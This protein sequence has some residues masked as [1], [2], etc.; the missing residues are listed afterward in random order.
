MDNQQK[1]I[2]TI[3]QE[4]A[5]S[6]KDLPQHLQEK[7]FELAVQQLS[8][9]I[10]TTQSGAATLIIDSDF[11]EKLTQETAISIDNLKSVYKL[12]KNGILKIV[13]PLNGKAAEKQRMLAYLYLLGMRLGYGKEWVSALEF[14]ERA[15][16]Y[17]TNDGHISKN[18][19]Q[20]KHNI[21]QEGTKRGKEYALSPNGVIRAKD[22]LGNIV[23]K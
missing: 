16:E 10:R 20:E 8:S 7:A 15:K 23:S 19:R 21:L 4:A 11:F 9:S 12:D 3:F 2:K 6:V 5:E 17:G 13:V 14:A 22:I 1:D 18:L